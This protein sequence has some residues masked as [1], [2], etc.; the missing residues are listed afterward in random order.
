MYTIKQAAARSGV[1]VPLLRAWERRYGVV[2]PSRSP[3]GYRLYEP[4]A[5]ERLRTMRQLVEA[6]WSPRQA[7]D[8]LSRV[9][10]DQLGALA[11]SVG[12][13]DEPAPSAEAP[14][15]VERFVRATAVLDLAA[16]ERVLDDAQAVGSFERVAQQVLLPALRQV[17]AAWARGEVDVAAEHAASQ[18]VMRR[19]AMAFEAASRGVQGPRVLIGLPHGARHEVAAL[20][21]AVAARRS[22]LDALYLGADVPVES[23]SRAVEQ[24][25]PAAVVLGAIV[26]RDADAAAATLRQLRPGRPHLV[27]AVGGAYAEGVNVQGVLR[28]PEPIADAVDRLRGALPA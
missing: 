11:A 6:G 5:I 13:E 15:L 26:Q 16:L 2:S 3:A 24:T 22:G 21:F 25:D 27:M 8:E 14:Q 18:A 17:G 10:D 9:A 19:L 28:L 4:A 7:A 20:A 1:S 23:W 12:G